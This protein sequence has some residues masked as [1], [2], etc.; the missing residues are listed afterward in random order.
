MVVV[1]VVVEEVVEEDEDEDDAGKTEGG[2][3]V[4]WPSC[5]WL[6]ARAWIWSRLAV[7]ACLAATA[8]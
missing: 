3:R 1:M 8:A 6:V 2:R 5:N 4:Q 7:S